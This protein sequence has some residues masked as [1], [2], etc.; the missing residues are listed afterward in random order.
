MAYNTKVEKYKH[1]FW[2]QDVNRKCIKPRGSSSYK[3][4]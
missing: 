3:K 1:P 4:K 2:Q